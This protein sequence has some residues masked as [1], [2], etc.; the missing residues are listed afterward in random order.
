[1][2]VDNPQEY[3]YLRE[4]LYP[5]ILELEKAQDSAWKENRA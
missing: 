1:M 3:T 4:Q 2:E 5:R